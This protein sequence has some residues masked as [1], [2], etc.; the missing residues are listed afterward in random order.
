MEKGKTEF[1]ECELPDKTLVIGYRDDGMKYPTDSIGMHL[2][3]HWNEA[4]SA[5]AHMGTLAMV[6]W[7]VPASDDSDPL[8]T[9]T[10]NSI[11]VVVESLI[12][13]EFRERTKRALK[14]THGFLSMIC[15]PRA[16]LRDECQTPIPEFIKK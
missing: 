13:R 6:N 9:S 15:E 16:P 11:Y 3:N 4:M 5:F 7:V 12:I 10:Y 1:R 8:F 2:I 14:L